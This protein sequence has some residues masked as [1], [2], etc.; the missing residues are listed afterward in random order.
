MSLNDFGHRQ[1]HAVN[2]TLALHRSAG[3]IATVTA[4]ATR[5]AA[6]APTVRIPPAQPPTTETVQ[7]ERGVHARENDAENNEGHG[8]RVAVRLHGCG[9]P[10]FDVSLASMRRSASCSP[11]ASNP[12]AVRQGP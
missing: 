11:H 1:L 3:L 5:T 10:F 8:K 9:F 6:D 12:R 4:A 2:E 7:D